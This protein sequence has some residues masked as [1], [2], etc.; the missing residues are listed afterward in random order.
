MDQ[1]FLI[2]NPAREDRE[3]AN[4]HLERCSTTYVIACMLSRFSHV[5]LF[6]TLWTSARFFCPWR[7]SR[8]EYCG[9]LPYSPSGDLP[10]PGVELASLMSPALAGGFFTTST[11]WEV[12]ICSSVQFSS[13]QSLSRVRLFVTP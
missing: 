6:V 1:R 10:D 11:T 12:L 9:G 7:F 2:D 3:V 8:Q 13:A 5:Q 4:Q